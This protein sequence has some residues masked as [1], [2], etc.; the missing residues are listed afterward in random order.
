MELK[1]RRQEIDSARNLYNYFKG[2]VIKNYS[3]SKGTFVVCKKNQTLLEKEIT[4]QNMRLRNK[5]LNVQSTIDDNRP[6][7]LRT[8]LRTP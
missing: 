7:P 4:A 2:S 5:I 1:A 6:T 3:K 8:P